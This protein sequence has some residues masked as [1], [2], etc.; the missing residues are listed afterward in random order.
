M[1]CPNCR[2]YYWKDRSERCHCGRF[3]IPD[4]QCPQ[5]GKV[6]D[7]SMT[8]KGTFTKGD[9]AIS[10]MREDGRTY[11]FF[12]RICKIHGCYRAERKN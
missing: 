8:I 6:G 7:L 9:P 3:T 5:C 12:I 11:L 2:R 1:K 10:V 4:E